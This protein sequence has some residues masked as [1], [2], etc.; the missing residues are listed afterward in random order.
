MAGNFHDSPRTIWDTYFG[1][2][3]LADDWIFQFDVPE[4]IPNSS[5]EHK[6]VI[7]VGGKTPP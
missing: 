6:T 1:L 4:I 7:S 5:D 3:S 2:V